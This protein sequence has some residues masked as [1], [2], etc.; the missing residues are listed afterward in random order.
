[1]SL[2]NLVSGGLDSTLIGVLS[3]EERIEIFPLFIDYGQRA[4]QRE[5]DT[6][7]SVHEQLSLPTPI[8]MD[9]SGFGKL[10][11]SGLTSPNLDIKIAAFTPGRNLLFLLVGSAYAYQVG[12]EAVAIGLLS[13]QF[14]LFPDQRSVFLEESERVIEAALG[15]RIKIV[16][17]LSDFSKADVLRLALEK[18]I[19]GTYSCHAGT[20]EPCGQCIS[21]LELNVNVGE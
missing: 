1:M 3:Q 14:S 13:E 10:I 19:S 17:P 18:K 8:R 12:A 5:W 16:A 15:K 9:L 6:C 21:C 7:L 11:C 2:V 20:N 4:A